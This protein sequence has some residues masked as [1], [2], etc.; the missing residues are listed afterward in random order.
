VR[1]PSL[2]ATT[3]QTLVRAA[4]AVGKRVKISLVNV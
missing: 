3:L 2:S 4:G 1:T